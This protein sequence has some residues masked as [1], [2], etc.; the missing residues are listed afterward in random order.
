MIVNEKLVLDPKS[1]SEFLRFAERPEEMVR[2]L[3]LELFGREELKCM[4]AIGYK[5]GENSGRGIPEII[6]TAVLGIYIYYLN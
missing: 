2:R 4:T 1:D 3:L 5:R 6:R